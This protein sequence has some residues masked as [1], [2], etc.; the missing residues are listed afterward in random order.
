MVI[1]YDNIPRSERARAVIA[2]IQSKKLTIAHHGRMEEGLIDCVGAML[3]I[4]TAFGLAYDHSQANA[5]YS[6]HWFLATPT[7]M[8]DAMRS[9]G[10]QEVR[11]LKEMD[12]AVAATV[13]TC[14]DHPMVYMGEGEFLHA[15][16]SARGRG[17]V[18]D[19]VA[20]WVPKIRV[21]FRP[22]GELGELRCQ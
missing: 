1:T 12:V 18:L 20:G 19:R 3:G 13:T 16:V 9:L 15:S 10:W 7:K 5:P 2:Y 17:I 14:G 8:I 4:H 11:H 22:V 6:K 21:V